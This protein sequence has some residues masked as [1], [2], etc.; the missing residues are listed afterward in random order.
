MPFRLRDDFL[1][2]AEHS[3]FQ[4]LRSMMGIYFIICPKVSLSDVFFIINPDKNMSAYNRINHKHVDFLICDSQTMR[5]RFAIEL[6]DKSHD[7]LDRVERDAF[8]DELFETA[9]LPL[10][11]IPVRS[12]YNTNELG[13]LF[14]TVLSGTQKPENV[15]PLSEQVTNPSSDNTLSTATMV[16][17]PIVGSKGSVTG[18]YS[19]QI[20]EVKSGS[21]NHT[22]VCPKC[23]QP[24]V[25][26]TAGEGPNKGNRFWGCVNFPKYKVI[27]K[28]E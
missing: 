22:P 15:N 20:S 21:E 24:M 28:I 10:V 6:D 2:T 18:S 19:S 23:G 12:T 5:P 26:R 11:H 16:N 9:Q 4:V 1:S 17:K 27:M 8:V 13:A 14:R 7:R 25:L 3:F